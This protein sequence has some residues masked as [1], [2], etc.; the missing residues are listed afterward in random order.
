MAQNGASTL[1]NGNRKPANNARSDAFSLPGI[2]ENELRARIYAKPQL[3][4]NPRALRFSGPTPVQLKKVS[5][6]VYL[7]LQIHKSCSQKFWYI[8]TTRAAIKNMKLGTNCFILTLCVFCM[9]DVNSFRAFLY[10]QV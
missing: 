4:P 5:L 9:Y 10:W 8:L 2:D 3:K 6:N 1:A 7:K